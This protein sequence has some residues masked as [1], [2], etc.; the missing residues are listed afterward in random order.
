MLF[1]RVFKPAEPVSGVQALS[2]SG[3]GFDRLH[4]IRVGL[5]R[6]GRPEE[7]GTGDEALRDQRE[8]VLEL[9]LDIHCLFPVLVLLLQRSVI[10]GV[11]RQPCEGMFPA[12]PGSDSSNVLMHSNT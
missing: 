10:A 6:S 8:R 1:K 11:G 5:G 3:C 12:T 4:L 9:L 2:G 7:N